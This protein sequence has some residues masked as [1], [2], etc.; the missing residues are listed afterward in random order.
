MPIPKDRNKTLNLSYDDFRGITI[1][2]VIS[3]ILE[4]C[5]LTYI[6]KYLL[7]DKRQFGFKKGR[8]LVAVMLYIW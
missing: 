3:K 8:V 1:N 2:P 7:T 5:L 6:N 4:C